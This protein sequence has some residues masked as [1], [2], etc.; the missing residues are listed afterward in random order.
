[1]LGLLVPWSFG[2]P[3]VGFRQQRFDPAVTLAVLDR[4]RVTTAFLPPS[5][6]RLLAGMASGRAAGSG[7]W[8]PAA[9]PPVRGRWHGRAATSR[10]RSTRL[11]A[12]PRRTL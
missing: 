4:Y 10:P 3:V 9:S 1:M 7:P 5:V 6:L 12:R 8:S 2:V 11:S